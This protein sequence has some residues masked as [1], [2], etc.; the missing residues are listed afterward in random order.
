MLKIANVPGLT[1][2]SGSTIADQLADPQDDHMTIANFFRHASCRKRKFSPSHS[3]QQ[4]LVAR[5][6][7]FSGSGDACPKKFA[8]RI[9]RFLQQWWLRSASQGH[10]R[11]IHR[12][13]RHRELHKGCLQGASETNRMLIPMMHAFVCASRH[14]VNK[15][16]LPDIPFVHCLLNYRK[17]P[18]QGSLLV[19]IG[20]PRLVQW[21][22]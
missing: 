11:C 9:C 21:R 13:K 6:I 1:L 15:N 3:E 17:F 5:E 19:Y 4:P 22:Q 7:F 8:I 12:L 16:A 2:P 20:R 10:H 14:R 18:C